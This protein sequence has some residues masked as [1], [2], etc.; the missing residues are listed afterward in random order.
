MSE[1]TMLRYRIS[2]TEKTVAELELKI[3]LDMSDL[4]QRLD[5]FIEDVSHL[6]IEE[7]RVHFD[8]LESEIIELRLS[9]DKLSKM[10]KEL[11]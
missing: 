8:R 9:K 1:L 7:C 6:K 10:Q 2:E 3:D 4:R 5:P 11:A